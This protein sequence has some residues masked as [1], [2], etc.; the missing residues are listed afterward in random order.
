MAQWLWWLH[1]QFLDIVAR[2][3]TGIRKIEYILQRLCYTLEIS[4][5]VNAYHTYRLNNGHFEQIYNIHT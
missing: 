4:H 2:P 3:L 1:C 5:A